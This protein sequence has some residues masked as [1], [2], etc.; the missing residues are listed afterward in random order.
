MAVM[1]AIDLDPASSEIANRT[2][3]ATRYYTKSDDG[4]AKKWRGRVW[5][6]PP[7]ASDLIGLFIDKLAQSIKGESVNECVVLVNNA[8]ETA[9]FCQLIEVAQA[10]VFTKGRIKFLDAQGKAGAPLQGQAIIYCGTQRKKFLAEFKC[11][12]WGAML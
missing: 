7:Y 5:L 8:T 10:V 9:W 11:F 12:G 2:V 3:K 4:L 6:N 1:G